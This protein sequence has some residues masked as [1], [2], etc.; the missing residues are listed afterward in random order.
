[1]RMSPLKIGFLLAGFLVLLGLLYGFLFHSKPEEVKEIEKTPST[2]QV[3]PIHSDVSVQ[4]GTADFATI[5]GQQ[6]V[7]SGSKVKTSGTG[8][9]LIE[10]TSSHITR[11]DY[12]SE[13]TISEEQKQTSV[14]LASGALWSRLANIFDSGESYEVQTPNAIAAVRGTSFGVW[15]QKN[16]TILIVIEGS[17]LFTPVGAEDKAVLVTAGYKATRV[18]T[19]PV[20]VE[21]L[22]KADRLLPW[23]V[24]NVDAV[25]PPP[26]TGSPVQS[27]ASPVTTT[28]TPTPVPVPV[29]VQDLVRLSGVSP[30]TV[31]EGSGASVTLSGRNLDQVLSVSIDGTSVSFS[32]VASTALA[33]TVPT[34]LAVGRHTISIAG[35]NNRVVTLSNALTVT[36]RV[37]SPNSIPGKP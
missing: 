36:A 34:S 27:P 20:V 16:T 12:D 25:T 19:G 32:V 24:F 37:A 9:A 21:P 23:V 14:A 33:V 7:E 29:P 30:T 2:V 8:R 26:S 3:T 5:T 11:L 6:R 35:P 31:E 17:V 10:S 1:M 22:T 15:Y 28:P 4:Q 13:I 18:G